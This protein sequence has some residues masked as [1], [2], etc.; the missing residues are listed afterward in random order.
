VPLVAGPSTPC[1]HGEIRHPSC[2]P[3]TPS[4]GGTGPSRWNCIRQTPTA[5]V[6]WVTTYM[7]GAPTGTTP[8]SMPVHRNA[9]RVGPAVEL[10]VPRAVAPG[11]IISRSAE[12]PRAPVFHQSSNI[13]TTVFESHGPRARKIVVVPRLL[14]CIIAGSAGLGQ[15]FCAGRNIGARSS[16]RVL[17]L[18]IIYLQILLR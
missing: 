16:P 12:P 9:I 4:G 13:P 1:T 14:E 10:A 18:S 5:F 8:T 3:I 15:R 7:N 11:D 6:I 2:F 17:S